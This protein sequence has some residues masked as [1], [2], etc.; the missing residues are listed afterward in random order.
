M[1]SGALQRAAAIQAS[2]PDS[3]PC[4]RNPGRQ[5]HGRA[6]ANVTGDCNH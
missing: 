4:R 6:L 3:L 2:V 5:V 1:S